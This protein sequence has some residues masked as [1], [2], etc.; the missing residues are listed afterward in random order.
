M[1]GNRWTLKDTVTNDVFSM[2]IN[3]DSMTSPEPDR[4]LTF[5]ASGFRNDRVRTYAVAP[6]A[7][8]WQWGGVMRD[9]AHH[10]AL[11]DYASRK[12]PVE[13]T[14]H[15]GRTYRVVITQ[16]DVTDRRPTKTVNWRLRYQMTV[17]IIRRI[18]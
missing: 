18:T 6:D 14:D 8:E 3:P 16:F 15:L 2:P 5:G 13:V 9:K 12:V 17:R 1:T 10:D 7:K 11:H 4:N